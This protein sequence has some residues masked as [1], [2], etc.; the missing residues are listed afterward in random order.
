MF[1]IFKLS[2]ETVDRA[3]NR[4]PGAVVDIYALLCRAFPFIDRW[5]GYS[6]VS[7]VGQAPIET[8]AP[9]RLRVFSGLDHIE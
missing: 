3:A 6:D 9:K 1:L 5:I 8:V 2:A 4:K 7:P